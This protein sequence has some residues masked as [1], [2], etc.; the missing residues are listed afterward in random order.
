MATL[1]VSIPKH[2]TYLNIDRSHKSTAA[3][4]ATKKTEDAAKKEADGR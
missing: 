4:A 3:A 1:H 2:V